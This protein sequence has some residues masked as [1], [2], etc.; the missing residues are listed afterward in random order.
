MK[1]LLGTGTFGQ[2]A[3]CEDLQSVG[4]HVAVKIIKNK[5]AYRR[6]AM[7]E[8]QILD[9]LMKVYDPEDKHHIVRMENH[10]TFRNHLCITFE[11]LSI[12]LYELIKS[13]RF[14]GLSTNLIGV[15]SRQVSFIN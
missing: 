13:N 11:L 15:F 12:N 3:R 7:I 2:V 10:F 1:D 6:Q 8:I 14:Q 9:Q 5:P 4:K